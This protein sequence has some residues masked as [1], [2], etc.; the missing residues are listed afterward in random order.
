MPAQWLDGDCLCFLVLGI[1][2]EYQIAWVDGLFLYG[3]IAC[4]S[5]IYSKSFDRSLCAGF[6]V[7]CKYCYCTENLV[8][9]SG[10]TCVRSFGSDAR[11]RKLALSAFGTACITRG[12]SITGTLR[13]HDTVSQPATTTFTYFELVDLPALHSLVFVSSTPKVPRTN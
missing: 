4:I 11:G 8:E 1:H 13:R 10:S 12:Q 3:R 6:E 9:C 5:E 7:S 2:L